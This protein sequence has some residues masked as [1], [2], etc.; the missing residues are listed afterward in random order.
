MLETVL[1]IVFL[2]LPNGDLREITQTETASMEACRKQA[3]AL[4]KTIQSGLTE[5]QA[6]TLVCTDSA[7]TVQFEEK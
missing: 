5:G 4:A 1:L 7:W 2:M 6:F 3:A